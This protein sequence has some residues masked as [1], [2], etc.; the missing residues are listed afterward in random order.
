MGAST[1]V[2]GLLPTG[3]QIGVAAPILL[4]V[5][6]S[7]QGLAAGG[8]YAGAA[9]F[10]AEYA[11]IGKRGAWASMPNRGGAVA[12]S[13][14]G[15]TF[16]ITSLT[17]SEE[18]LR[19]WGWRIPFLFSAVLVLFGLYIRLRMQETP[20][21]LS[22]AS[23][24]ASSKTPFLEAI[25]RQ[26]REILLGCMVVVPTFLFLYLV[27]TYVVNVGANELRL[28]YTWVLGM[29][30]ISGLL[31]L[32]GIIFTSKLSDRIGRRPI[33]IVANG[34]AAVWALALFPL[35]HTGTLI[36][37]AI[38]MTVSLVTAGCIAG[39][40][41]SFMSELFLTRYR[42]TAVGLCYNAAGVIGGA[43]P[44]LFAGRMITAYGDLALGA[45][46]SAVCV[47]SL[48]CCIALPETRCRAL[49]SG[50]TRD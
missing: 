1:V 32:G 36:S 15:L 38:C 6:R 46:L 28:G 14:A 24:N 25:H 29:T 21:F 49:D 22:V 3:D 47:I 23:E 45:V 19:G 12:Q 44:P 4:V 5:L 42:Y 10:V 39:P 17:M 7:L 20:V 11:P 9:L 37:Y 30:V 16:L 33:F 48:L 41:G 43:L 18:A 27:V 26:W 50:D 8:E 2:V 35:L 31:M 13:T 40:I 34:F